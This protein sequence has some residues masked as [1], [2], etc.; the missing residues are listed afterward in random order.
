MSPWIVECV[1][2]FAIQY[3]RHERI[4]ILGVLNIIIHEQHN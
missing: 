3:G 2:A 4:H 1:S